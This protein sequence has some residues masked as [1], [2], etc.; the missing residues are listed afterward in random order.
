M[1]TKKVA[2]GKPKRRTG[3]VSVDPKTG[4]IKPFVPTPEQRQLVANLAGINCTQEEIVQ[5]VPWGRP[6]SQPLNVDTMRKHFADELARGRSLAAMRLKK[7]AAEMALDG[8]VT[9][10]IF[11]L[12]TQ[13]GYSETVKV[14]N[15]GK[16][17]APLAGPL[18]YMPAKG[19]FEAPAEG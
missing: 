10:M 4:R 1:A 9:M 13:H 19:A 16:D 14:E 15:T 6:D 8:N 12:K 5:C 18:L 11:L 7:K 3:T 17:G 2:T